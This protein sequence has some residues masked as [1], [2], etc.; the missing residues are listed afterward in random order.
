MPLTC[1][2][3]GQTAAPPAPTRVV[4]REPGARARVLSSICAS[5][6]EQWEDVEVRA[7]N[8]YRLNLVDPEDRGQLEAAALE[9]LFG[10][11]SGPRVG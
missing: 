11:E 1:S 4:F 3:C 7:I 5:C 2:R 9:F 6:F 10:A 8:E